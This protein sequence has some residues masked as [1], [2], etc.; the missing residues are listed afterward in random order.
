MDRWTDKQVCA[1]AHTHTRHTGV[2]AHACNPM[3][4]EAQIGRSLESVS[5][6]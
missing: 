2:V 1:R 3:T 5:L 4:E 6:A